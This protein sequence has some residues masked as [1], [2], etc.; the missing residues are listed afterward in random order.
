MQITNILRRI[1]N[2]QVRFLLRVPKRII[3][4]FSIVAIGI[5]FIISTKAATTSSAIEVESGNLSGGAVSVSSSSASEAA[6]IQFKTINTGGGND[7]VLTGVR[8][9]LTL[10]EAGPYD[11]LP[12]ELYSDINVLNIAPAKPNTEPRGFWKYDGPHNFQNDPNLDEQAYTDLVQ[13]VRTFINSKNCGPTLV[14]GASN[15]AAF[16]AKL[17]CRG[18]TFENRV[19]GFFIDDPVMDEG[20]LNCAPSPN[21]TKVQFIHSRQLVG[22]AAATSPNFRC[23]NVVGQWYC[24]NDKTMTLSQYQNRIGRT[25]VLHRE[26]HYVDGPNPGYAPQ[27][28]WYSWTGMKGGTFWW[29]DWMKENQPNTVPNACS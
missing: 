15:G 21:F 27:F 26:Y 3:L 24:E 13:H 5:V 25:S 16:A 12:D 19:W 2:V 9:T 11:G 22:D 29:C 28:D 6:A 7:Q 17:Y 23:T 10:R 14:R 4:A 1:Y 18:E 20:V 8:C